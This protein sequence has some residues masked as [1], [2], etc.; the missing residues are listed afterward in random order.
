MLTKMTA[1]FILPISVDSLSF[2][3]A[4]QKR[5]AFGRNPSVSDKTSLDF[6]ERKQ[7]HETRRICDYR[8]RPYPLESK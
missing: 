8:R 5:F 7:V 1:L 4:A 3:A 6:P 2:A